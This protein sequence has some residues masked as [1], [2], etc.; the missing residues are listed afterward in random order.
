MTDT[1]FSAMNWCLVQVSLVALIGIVISLLLARRRPLAASTVACVAS[2]ACA[3]LTFLAPLSVHLMFV[4]ET[5]SELNEAIDQQSTNIVESDKTTSIAAPQYISMASL[6]DL[7]RVVRRLARTVDLREQRS[8]PVSFSATALLIGFIAVGI[9]RLATGIF[10]VFNVRR[11]AIAINDPQISAILSEIERRFGNRTLLKIY[12]NPEFRDAAVAG[13]LHPRLILP[14]E[15]RRWSQDERRAVLAHEVAHIVHNDAIWRTAASCVLAIHFYNPVVHW[16][17][18]RVFICQEL[19][20]DALAA[21]IVGQ[22]SYLRSLSSLAIR[23]D[24]LFEATASP[25]VLPVF[26]GHLI[27]RIKALHSREGTLDMKNEHRRTLT[28][29]VISMSFIVV[30]FAALATRGIAQ[31]PPESTSKFPEIIRTAVL[32][33]HGAENK[34]VLDPTQG[35]FLRTPLDPSVVDVNNRFGM[36]A[37][38]VNELLGHPEIKSYATIAN[39]T[40]S[41]ALGPVLKSKTP[42]VIRMENIDWIAARPNM[43]LRA[44]TRDQKGML[45]FGASGF[46]IKLNQPLNLT[47]WVETSAPETK[48]Y[49]IEGKDVFEFPISAMGPLSTFVWMPDETTVCAAGKSP[50]QQITSQSKFSDFNLDPPSTRASQSETGSETHANLR[51]NTPW[52]ATWNRM[53]RGIFSVVIA[54]FD[55]SG[56][57]AELDNNPEYQNDL[58]LKVEPPI[59]SI[60]SRYTMSALSFDLAKG[61]SQ[62]GIRAYLTHPSREEALKSEQDLQVLLAIAKEEIEKQFEAPSDSSTTS[63]T[64]DLHF[65]HELL[66][67]ALV[68]VNDHEDGTADVVISTAIPISKLIESF[69]GAS[70]AEEPSKTELR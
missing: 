17:L 54:K 11:K 64:D 5:H 18:R 14:L 10:F 51:H 38:R 9:I 37:I 2:V 55:A 44:K 61:S 43:T 48:R 63:E 42:M 65:Y 4:V 30:G 28:T 50:K 8:G 19:S 22:K 21:I 20:A 6:Q 23:R 40:L 13:W 12:E 29:A 31:Q 25:D 58:G 56:V 60:L 1:L 45:M 32:T 70:M 7:T 67:V 27:Q 3:F 34:A 35:M 39:M 52:S 49:V 47:Q 57:L 68:V 15:W 36:G 59:R 69:S 66:K 46:L 16:L 24:E 62:F 41:E 33:N 26:S 53:D